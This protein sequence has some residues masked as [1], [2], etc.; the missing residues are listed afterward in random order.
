MISDGLRSCAA[1]TPRG[2]L[3]FERRIA[4]RVWIAVGAIVIAVAVMRVLGVLAAVVEFLAVGS[5]VAFIASPMVRALERKGVPRGIGALIGLLVIAAVVICIGVVLVPVFAQQSLEILTRLPEQLRSL[6]EWVVS[7]SQEFRSLSQSAWASQLDMALSSLADVASSY[8]RQVASDVGEGVFP[9]ISA[10]AWQLFIFFLGLVLAYWLARDYP[11]IHR[12]IGILVGER[13][14]L[15]YH[16]MIAIIARSVGGYMRGMVITSLINGVLAYAG[17]L[18]IGHPYAALMA[19]LAALFHL[20]PVVGPWVSCSIATLI[21][22]FY[23][24]ALAA[25]TLVVAVVSQNITD[26]VISPKIMQSAVQVHPAMSLT[27]IVAGS[28]LMGALGMVIA[29]PLCAALKG[30]FIF[31]FEGSTKRA[32][33]SPDGAIFKGRPFRDADGQPV[34]AYDALGDDSFIDEMEFLAE[35]RAASRSGSPKR[36][37][38]GSGCSSLPADVASSPGAEATPDRKDPDRH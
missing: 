21:A 22:V 4:L 28:A 6:G 27:A 20:V 12:E 35:K 36:G 18:I 9:F 33:I 11:R 34:A 32:L 31:Y 24:P 38:D 13:H 5:L 29:I 15:N 23:S 10:F 1:R 30:L 3:P 37:E 14:E 8:M 25:W 2:D 16:F 17:F 26:N 19:V 7:V